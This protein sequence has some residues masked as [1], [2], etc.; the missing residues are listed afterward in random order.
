MKLFGNAKRRKAL[1]AIVNT[2]R[3]QNL[4]L[5]VTGP[6]RRRNGELVFS[7]GDS[8]VT[9]AE[10]LQLQQRGELK[11]GRIVESLGRGG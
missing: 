6:Y 8:V 5:K 11:A 4:N 2:L 9:E 7:V 3:K 1:S 10:L